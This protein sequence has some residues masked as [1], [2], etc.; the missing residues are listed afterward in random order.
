MRDVAVAGA[1][2]LA[3]SAAL[4]CR[5][6][7]DGGRGSNKQR[8]KSDNCYGQ[9]EGGEDDSGAALQPQQPWWLQQ[10]DLQ[11][12]SGAAGAGGVQ[13]R[14]ASCSRRADAI[15]DALRVTSGSGALTISRRGEHY[16]TRNT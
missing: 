11:V 5:Q 12:R 9:N 14:R 15:I 8:R 10:Q 16:V 4:Q 2:S 3:E 7:R 1:S 13:G 6:R